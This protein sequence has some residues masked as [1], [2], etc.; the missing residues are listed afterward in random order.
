MPQLTDWSE[1]PNIV[2]PEIRDTMVLKHLY[3]VAAVAVICV[4]SEPSYI[5]LIT[6]VLHSLIPLVPAEIGGGSV[7]V[8]KGASNVAIGSSIATDGGTVPG[9]I[10][11]FSDVPGCMLSIFIETDVAT[12]VGVDLKIYLRSLVYVLAFGKLTE[13]PSLFTCIW[14]KCFLDL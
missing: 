7:A 5:H 8:N 12:V 11:L 3:Q 14:M 10:H 1:L 6:D 9:G 13:S 4:Q 2:D